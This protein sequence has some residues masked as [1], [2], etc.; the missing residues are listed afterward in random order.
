MLSAFDEGKMGR[1]AGG[2]RSFRRAGHAFGQS[3]GR[4]EMSTAQ[5]VADL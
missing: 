2:R 1:L 3:T 5:I 4:D